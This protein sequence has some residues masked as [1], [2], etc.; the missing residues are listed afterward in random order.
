MKKLLLPAAFVLFCVL[1]SAQSANYY[2]EDGSFYFDAGD[3]P[4]AVDLW[5]A[6]TRETPADTRLWFNLAL[7]QLE[8]HRYADAATSLRAL[9]VLTPDDAQAHQLL[10]TAYD[11]MG[12]YLYAADAFGESYHLRPAPATLLLR[13]TVYRKAAELDLAEA[14]YRSALAAGADAALAHA[15]LGDVAAAR[16]DYP[17]AVDHYD[18]ALRLAPA[19]A[20]TLYRRGRAKMAL[21]YHDTAIFDL[22]RAIELDPYLDEYYAGRALCR[23]EIADPYGAAIDARRARRYNPENADAWFA[24]GQ[25]A[26]RENDYYAAAN[27]FNMALEIR[28]DNADYHYAR[29]KVYHAIE[30]YLPAAE[31][32]RVAST[33]DP[34]LAEIDKWRSRAERAHAATLTTDTPLADAPAPLPTPAEETPAAPAAYRPYVADESRRA[35]PAERTDGDAIDSWMLAPDEQ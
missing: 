2:Y 5:R 10:G 24:L 12:Q 22:S 15:G 20:L 1:A 31:D 26:A 25:L 11:G 18:A 14:D 13:A 28:D 35:L 17:S 23:L 16:A 34:E 7:A 30:A 33:L 9:V 6:G 8:L 21:G 19:D 3:Y 4:R 32:F 29:G 27:G